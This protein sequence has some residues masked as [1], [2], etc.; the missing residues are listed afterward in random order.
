MPCSTPITGTAAAVKSARR[1][2]PGLSRRMSL[3]PCTL[4]MPTAIVKTML[5]NTQCG[6]YCNGPVRNKSTTS[7][8]AAKASCAT[9]LR[10]PASS[11]MA[12]W[13]GLPLTTKAPLIAA[14]ALAAARRGRR[15][16]CRRA[17]VRAVP[18]CRS[19]AGSYLDDADRPPAPAGALLVEFGA[20]VE[21]AEAGDV[22]VLEELMV[23]LA[24]GDLAAVEALGRHAFELLRHRLGVV[25]LGLVNRLG[26]HS[27]LV[28]RARIK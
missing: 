25:G 21:R 12:V 22:N 5:A 27:H 10:A 15:R 19:W 23:V 18:S 28:H 26:E 17:P 3:R 2:S 6:R 11:A 24:H 20:R 14:P 8:T 16:P 7:T 13:V 4:T 9:W 1:N